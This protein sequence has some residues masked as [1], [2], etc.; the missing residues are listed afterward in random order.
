MRE[1]Y[2]MPEKFRKALEEHGLMQAYCDRPPYQQNDYIGWYNRAK[3]E[4]TRQKR[5]DQMIRELIR[6]DLYMG[7]DYRPKKREEK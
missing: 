3:M 5:L 1:R 7:M 2:P 4:P 6:G